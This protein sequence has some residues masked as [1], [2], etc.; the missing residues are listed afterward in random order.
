MMGSKHVALINDEIYELGERIN[1]MTIT[2]ITLKNVELY[3]GK[4]V[5]IL[6]VRS[7]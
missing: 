2:K 4:N 5:V 6:D 7:K 3:D 1:G